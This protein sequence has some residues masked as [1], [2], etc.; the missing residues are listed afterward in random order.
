MLGVNTSSRPLPASTYRL[1][2]NGDFTFA[3]ATAQV[4]YLANLGVTHIFCSPILQAAPGSRHGYDVTDH[5][6]I[7]VECGGETGFRDFAAAA[8]DAGLGIVVDVVPNHMAVPTPLWHNH[9]MWD[10]LRNGTDSGFAHWFDLDLS[11]PVLMPVLGGRIGQELEAGSISVQRREIDGPDGPHLE[12]VVVYY[13]NVFPVKPGTEDIPIAELLDQQWYRLAYWKVGSEELNYRRF[14]DVDT[15]AA[16]RVE[17]PEVFDA[18]HRLLIQLHSEGLIDGFRIDHPDGLANPREYLA[19]LQEATGGAWV[20]VEKILEAEETLSEDFKCAG[21]TGYDALLRVGG[22][23]QDGD[24]LPRLTDLWDRLGDTSDGFHATL[25]KA[26]KEVAGRLL[27]TEVNRLTAIA[28]AICESD[29]RLRDHTRRQLH[30]AIRALLIEMDRYRAYVEPGR[31]AD[32]E[33]R[34]VIVAAADRAR[35]DLA[36]DEQ[37]SLDLIVALACGEPGTGEPEQGAETLPAI[38]D[39]TDDPI[40]GLRAEFMIRFAQTCGPVMAKSKEDTAFYR[41]NRFVAVNEVGC[42]PTWVGMSPDSFHDFSE[43]INR[44]WPTTMTTLSTH[45]TKRSADVRARIAAQLEHAK[46]WTACVDELRAATTE[47]RSELV[48]GATELLL[49]QTLAA[50]WALPGTLTG[51]RPILRSRLTE[52]LLKAMREAKTH[53]TWTEPN[54]AYEEAVLELAITALTDERTVAIFDEFAETTTESVRTALLGQ[55]LVQLT[56]PGVPDIYQG[57]EIVDLSLVDPDNR[58]AIDF[59]ARSALLDDLETQAPTTLDA[60]KLLV[61]SR[62]LRLRRDHPAAFA[63]PT[64]DYRPVAT[65]SGHAVAFARGIAEAEQVTAVTVATRL[66]HALA[67]RG[68]WGEHNVVLP[69]GRFTDVLTGREFDG[70]Q[71]LLAELLDQL[72]VALLA[73]TES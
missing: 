56:M 70:G 63:G 49:W 34:G 48:D 42:E 35:Y 37:V 59:E 23:F 20:V 52:Y 31:V 14:F 40:L 51:R 17:R 69:E 27:V 19:R 24:S 36:E 5:S 60:E 45:D 32:V 55:K 2:L 46:A 61:V 58:R 53:T 33:E 4:P 39:A 7:W 65:T 47:Y 71:V 13:D 1:Q 72:P 3:D 54:Q 10:V 6:V 29:I 16:V 8:H 50:C 26:K 15:L 30:R 38:P 18:T 21:T 43:R 67:E 57:C 68:G 11:E 12:P 25:V 22:L 64:A 44:D 62:A 28:V 9:A 66:P 73:S 41:W